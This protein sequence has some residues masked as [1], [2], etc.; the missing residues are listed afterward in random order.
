MWFFTK[1]YNSAN[2]RRNDIRKESGDRKRK[3]EDEEGVNEERGTK[4]IVTPY[5][6]ERLKYS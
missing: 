4:T 5:S 3:G 1:K 6:F 2:A